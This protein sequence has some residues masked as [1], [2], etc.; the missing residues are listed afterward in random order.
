MK[1]RIRIARPVDCWDQRLCYVNG[2]SEAQ[3]TRQSKGAGW[4]VAYASGAPF[5]D[6]ARTLAALRRKIAKRFRA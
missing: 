6:S 2:L 1:P 5:T 4:R 3:V